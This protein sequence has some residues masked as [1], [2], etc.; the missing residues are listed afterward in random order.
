MGTLLSCA[1]G[2]GGS[3]W[4]EGHLGGR[5]EEGSN[6]YRFSMCA[7]SFIPQEIN[8]NSVWCTRKAWGLS[9]LSM[10]ITY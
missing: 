3:P 8:V 9:D 10:V 4:G 1:A 5:L 6:I 2:L 7:M